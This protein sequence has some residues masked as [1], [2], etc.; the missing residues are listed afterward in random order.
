VQTYSESFNRKNVHPMRRPPETLAIAGGGASARHRGRL[1]C[2]RPQAFIVGRV[3]DGR[4]GR[5]H[6]SSGDPVAELMVVAHVEQRARALWRRV[7]PATAIEPASHEGSCRLRSPGPESR[8]IRSPVLTNE[9]TL[10]RDRCKPSRWLRDH[11]FFTSRI[12]ALRYPWR[13]ASKPA[14]PASSSVVASPGCLRRL[15]QRQ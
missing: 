11:G 13:L 14:A 4:P 12:L 3:A 15:A 5:N 8:S 1:R 9:G 10:R 7:Q 2:Q 6:S